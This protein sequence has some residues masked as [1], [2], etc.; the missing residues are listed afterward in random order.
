MQKQ[1]EIGFNYKKPI[2]IF[3]SFILCFVILVETA[4]LIGVISF[5]PTKYVFES[6]SAGAYNKTDTLVEFLDVGQGDCTVIKVKDKCA[7]VD[8]GPPDDCKTVYKGLKKLGVEKIDLAFVT[9]LH[10][11][12]FGGLLSLLNNVSVENLVISSSGAEDMDSALF[13]NLINS[14]LDKKVKIISPV[15]GM[16]FSLNNASFR[17]VYHNPDAKEE[18]NRSIAVSAEIENRK[19]LFTG[20]LNGEG[21]AELINR[22]KNLDADVLKLGHHGSKTS[23]NIPLLEITTPVITI[24]SCGYNNLYNHP[25]KDLI[26]RLENKGIKYYRTDLDGSI[27]L[28]FENNKIIADKEFKFGGGQT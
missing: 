9:H 8:F 26:K 1:K 23:A 12:H 21:E 13:N 4:C 28:Y 5:S 27:K 11:D 16:S 19:I 15:E 25:A 14:V 6:I 3:L 22:C 20:D 7:V 18:N 10:N 17:V 24:A 2:I